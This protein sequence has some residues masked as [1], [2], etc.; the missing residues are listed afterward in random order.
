MTA[1]E[2]SGCAITGDART[3]AALL[4]A[5]PPEI[6]EAREALDRA[7]NGGQSHVTLDLPTADDLIGTV[8]YLRR[9]RD[10]LRAAIQT[11]VDWHTGPHRCNSADGE[12]RITWLSEPLDC[13]VRR[14]LLASTRPPGGEG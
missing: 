2:P 1:P 5:D 3:A 6:E 9:Q 4:S 13:P 10:Q 12:S 7:H 8:D 14:R 11:E